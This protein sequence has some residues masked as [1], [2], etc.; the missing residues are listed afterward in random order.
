MDSLW[1]VIVKEDKELE[2]KPY[3]YK[4]T[5]KILFNIPLKSH[6]F[7]KRVGKKTLI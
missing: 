5:K 6:F 1:I 4:Q 3:F 7:L 2:A